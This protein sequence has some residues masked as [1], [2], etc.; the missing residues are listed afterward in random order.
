M[1]FR[2]RQ[3][4]CGQLFHRILFLLAFWHLTSSTLL[5]F[6]GSSGL[7]TSGPRALWR[8]SWSSGP[9]GPPGS[10]ALLALWPSGFWHSRPLASSSLR[11]FVPCFG[12]WCLALGLCASLRAFVPRFRPL[13]L[14]SGLCASLRALVTLASSGMPC[15]WL[16]GL[17][18]CLA[19][20]FLAYFGNIGRTTLIYFF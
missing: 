13:C 7:R 1:I 3:R 17:L 20:G 14:A 18:A 5:V 8:P 2:D 10:L 6:F 12:P 19:S 15:F 11:A 16:S 9:P 4:G